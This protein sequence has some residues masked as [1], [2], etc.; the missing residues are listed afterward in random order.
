M[1]K[2]TCETCDR[3][4]ASPAELNE[5]LALHQTCGR[6]GCT[7]TA[8]PKVRKI[9]TFFAFLYMIFLYIY[10]VLVNLANEKIL[11]FLGR[12]QTR[13]G[14]AWHRAVC[15]NEEGW[16]TVDRTAK[17]EISYSS[18]C[19]KEETG[20]ARKNWLVL[21]LNMIALWIII[22]HLIS[23]FFTNCP[24]NTI[25]E[26]GERIE[27]PNSRFGSRGRGGWRGGRR[28]HPYQRNTQHTPKDTCHL[29][30]DAQ[31]TNLSPVESALQEP[32]PE[33]AAVKSLS[34]VEVPSAN[35]LCLAPSNKLLC[36]FSE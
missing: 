11:L 25:P 15:A 8:H 3:Y 27:K 19:G 31:N 18:M 4:F 20:V 36:K 16:G 26:R 12:R 14:T 1:K 29:K 23:N 32:K 7:F 2:P 21:S 17:K 22:K 9:H 30:T 6:E 28:N 33:N 35:D 13:W 5:H 10:T 34:E 24:I